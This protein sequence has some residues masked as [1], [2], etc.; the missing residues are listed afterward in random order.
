MVDLCLSPP[1]S[2]PE[3]QE[4]H[5]QKMEDN[6]QKPHAIMIAYPLQGHV[7]PCVHL[8]T[9]LASN[10]FTITFVNT[11][12]IHHKISTA[13]PNSA[14]DD[15]FVEARQSGL[16]IRYMTV[17]DGLPVEFDRNLH[18]DQF[19]DALLHVLPVHVDELVGKIVRNSDPPVCCLIADTFH[20]FSPR[21]ADKYK[22]V[23]VSFWT[24]PA[25]VFTL[26]YHLDLLRSNG[27]FDSIN[28]NRK[29]NIDYIPGVRS[30]E[31]KDLMSFLQEIDTSTGL[32]RMIFKSFE[33]VKRA[34][35]IICNTV[36]E[37]EC[38][39]ISALHKKQPTFA[40]GPIFPTS[41]TK[42]I[43]ATSL[44]SESDCTQWLNTKSRGSVLYVSF[45]SLA[46][47][48]KKDI[49][50]IAHGLLLSRVNFIWVLRP[51]IVSSVE[52]YSLPVGF[53]DDI[54]DKGLILPWCSQ[55]AVISHPSIGGFLTHCGWNS[56]LESIKCAVPLLCFPLFTDQ[57]TNRKLVVDD[58]RIGINLCDKNSITR[59]EVAE[60][61]NHLMGGKSAD[62]LRKLIKKVKRTMESALAIDGSSEKN[63]NQF[64][65][66]VKVKIQENNGV[67]K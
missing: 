18:L 53:E 21:I 32:H 47:V 15:L 27:H 20:E 64:I 12:A 30:I 41:F 2:F 40:I 4:P 29:D 26:Y 37:F 36:E 62:E 60:K 42:S 50:E 59:Q 8:A 31:P 58:W 35:F 1:L 63:F 19:L 46:N 54:K 45:G 17:S 14:G 9:K 66:D 16:D 44:W 11:E 7:T 34:D 48:S 65:Q 57:L 52:S 55:I 43:V 24:E 25:L 56:I 67:A 5:K 61:I 33:E 3:K 39:T 10:G 49:V 51:N 23:N 6:H 13:H 38:E 22:L 28:G